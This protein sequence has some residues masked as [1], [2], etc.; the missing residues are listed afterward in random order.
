MGKA[1]HEGPQIITRHGAGRGG[2]HGHRR[3][4]EA[5]GRVVAATAVARDLTLVTRN[6]KDFDGSV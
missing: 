6:V 1:H 5:Q 4:P 2:H 3:V